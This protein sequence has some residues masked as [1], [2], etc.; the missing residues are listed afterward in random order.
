MKYSKQREMILELVQTSMEHPSADMI[1]EQA[2]KKMPNISLGT[3]YRNLNQLVESG[4]IRKILTGSCD[5]FDKTVKD[6]CHFHCRKCNGVMDLPVEHVLKLKH[7]LMEKTGH[8]IE[9]EELL[10]SGICVNCL[11][12]EKEGN[13]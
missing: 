1:Y 12:E 2:R 3:V 8:K 6:H 7:D 10:F 9:C 5:R 4:A 11:K 13:L